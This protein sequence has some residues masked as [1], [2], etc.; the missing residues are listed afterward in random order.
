MTIQQTYV[1]EGERYRPSGN[2]GTAIDDDGEE[3]PLPRKLTDFLEGAETTGGNT[4]IPDDFPH[5]DILTEGNGLRYLEELVDIE[6]FTT[7]EGIGESKA[8]DIRDAL[9]KASLNRKPAPTE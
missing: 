2:E 5:A 4:P 9:S 8:D 6:D 3:V 7:L 1:F